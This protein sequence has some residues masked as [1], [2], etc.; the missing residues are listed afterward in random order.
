[1]G[2]GRSKNEGGDHVGR[3]EPKKATLDSVAI[4]VECEHDIG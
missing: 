4:F 2:V 1:M 3:L